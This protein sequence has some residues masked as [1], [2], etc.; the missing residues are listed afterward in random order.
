[1]K[2]TKLLFMA[3]FLYSAFLFGQ[4]PSGYYDNAQGKT[5][6]SLKT[7]LSTIISSGYVTYSYSDLYTIYVDSDADN[8][9]EKNGSVLDI[10]SENPSGGDPYEYTQ[11]DDKC[12]TYTSEGNCYNREHIVP[13]SVF[14]SES[15]MVSDAH[16]VVPVDGY[17]NG[18]RS[19]YPF[20]EVSNP[21][22]TSMNGGKLGPNTTAGYSGTVFEPIDEFKGDI[23]RMLFYF[24]TRY[25]SQ[26]AS[27]S[28]DMLNGT[29]DQVFSDWFLAV[30]LS[31]NQQD[32][33]SQR[34]IDRNNAI[35]NYQ[36]NRNPFIDHPEWVEAIWGQNSDGGGTGENANAQ[37]IKIM[38]FDGSQ[39][40]WN[41]NTDIAFFDNGSDGFFGIHNANEND[42]DGLPIDTG[43]ASA[44]DV[45]L[46]DYTAISGDFLFI[47]DLDDE[48][49]NGTTGEAVL[50]FDVI[51]ISQYTQVQISFDFDI[52][53]FDSADYIK[54]EIIEDGN[55]GG[56]KLLDKNGEGHIIENITEG[57]SQVFIRFHIKQNGASDQ[58]AIDNIKIAGVST[59][60]NLNCAY[61]VQTYPYNQ[62]FENT[63]GNWNQAQEDDFDWTLK[64][65]S[66]PSSGTGPSQASEG[67]YYIYMESSSPNYSS[68]TAI[69]ESPCFELNMPL[70]VQ[71]QYHMYG[72]DNMGSLAF[73]ISEDD[74]ATWTSLWNK[75]G[76]QGDLWKT[77]TVD[78]NSYEGQTIK[79][80]FKGITGSTWQGD[81]AIDNFKVLDSNNAI[82]EINLKLFIQFD[83]YPEETSWELN[84]ANGTVISQGGPYTN[85]AKESSIGIDL[86][87]PEAC[88]TL[89]MKDSYGDGM[90]CNYGNGY[91]SL[92][93]ADSGNEILS[94][95]SFQTEESQDFCLD[96]T[97]M[98]T[99]SIK[100][101]KVIELFDVYPNPVRDNLSIRLMDEK[102]K[103]Y[104]ILDITGKVIIKGDL[105]GTMINVSDLNSGIYIFKVYEEKKSLY[106]K[107]IKL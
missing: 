55:S 12:T 21:T 101:N 80:R 5:G 36:K 29:S 38:D 8:Y 49:D 83:Q 71:F 28:H 95:G 13:Q 88:Y 32:P 93:Y 10:Y 3:L 74:G 92:S 16:F 84:D 70:T 26:V 23:A 82:Q 67:N 99:K 48:G 96:G 6:Y 64:S 105:T 94:G 87:V 107:F 2:S 66:T 44:S 27:W 1:M 59:A 45:S 54:Y 37:L 18:R 4:I 9:Y 17:V 14:N 78:L 35:Y 62:S 61:I 76:N 85:Q 51:D 60:N 86:I 42:A 73:E 24:A 63:L 68:K 20:G 75:S 19:N 50:S 79:F 25:E 22:W 91:Y 81:M 33:V 106:K 34:E 53:G 41:F 90:C 102:M 30:L 56:L 72:A 98:K 57:T 97:Q 104:A 31:W 77:A 43:V 11:I 7:A 52:V 40:Q 69:L 39:P 15:P 100:D 46:I 65:G 58:A 89:I 47:N 103:R